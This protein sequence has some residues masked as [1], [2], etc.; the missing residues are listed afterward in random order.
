MIYKTIKRS[1]EN[2]TL[3]K[4]SILLNKNFNKKMF[5]KLYNKK[6]FKLNV[7]KIKRLNKK[8]FIISKY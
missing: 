8:L 5:K 3:G 1:L 7:I 6:I 4:I 2:N